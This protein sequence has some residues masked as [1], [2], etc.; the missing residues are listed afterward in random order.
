MGAQMASTL[1][2]RLDDRLYQ[3]LSALAAAQG[4]TLS[5]LARRTLGGLVTTPTD[6]SDW[7]D[8]A[9]VPDSL[10]TVRRHE[11]ALLHRIAARLYQGD[12]S[13]QDD[14]HT[15]A[16]EVFEN[17][18]VIEYPD[19]LVGVDA[20]LSRREA[21]LVMDILE[22]YTRL[23]WSY[24]ELT[25]AERKSLGPRAERQVRFFGFDSNSRFEGRLLRY[26]RHLIEQDRW[27][28]LAVYFD[29]KHES[30]NSHMPSVDIYERMLAEFNPIWKRKIREMGDYQLSAQ[31]VRQVIDAKVH[32][33]NRCQGPLRSA[34]R[35]S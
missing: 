29:S 23:E 30:G 25:E 13:G 19:V 4:T 27:T 16:A 11:L 34:Q 28:E 18:Y 6:S 33:D 31:E 32:P 17:G 22:M 7:V 8:P 15:G 1:T 35:R 3:E 9:K 2:V 12:P 5:E 21:E 10:T 26:A 24:N 14:Y 20:E